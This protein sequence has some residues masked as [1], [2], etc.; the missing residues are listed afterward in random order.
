MTSNLEDFWRVEIED[1]GIVWCTR[2]PLPYL[3]VTMLDEVLV[4]LHRRLEPIYR[5]AHSLLLDLR[6][7][8]MVN[9]GEWTSGALLHH[10]R[11]LVRNFRRAG[12]LI[13]S[14]E[15][16]DPIPRPSGPGYP[17]IQLFRDPDRARG[18]MRLS[19]GTQSE[20]IG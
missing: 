3:S 13:R 19:R 20:A 1:H 11:R 6:A 12:F 9:Q 15:Q 5:P 2:S 4:L 14:P 16:G 10:R 18:A 7:S 8:P 17:E